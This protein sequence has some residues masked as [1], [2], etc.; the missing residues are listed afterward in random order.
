VQQRLP[1]RLDPPITFAHRGARAHARENTL[2]A[3]ELALKLG[4]SGL[5]SDVWLTADGVAVLDH[6][7]VVK[8]G[9]RRKPISTVLRGD[10]PEHIPT[11]VELLE[12]CGT[13][14]ELSLDVKDPEAAA[15]IVDDV[16]S[17]DPAMLPRTWLCDPDFERCVAN[18]SELPDVKILN[19]TRLGRLKEGPERRAASLAHHGIDGIN[20]HRTDWNGGL[21]ALFH[22]FNLY[23]F[24][25]DL[26]FD[27]Q[28][29]TA[30]RMGLD[31]VFSDNVD[32][33]MDAFNKEIGGPLPQ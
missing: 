7:G 23:A 15:T 20:M 8:R 2:P 14:Y 17:I 19:S 25:W 12:H 27:D 22:R 28:L 24:G 9:I 32:I 26:Q 1:S 31:A 6:D 13:D 10:L 30:F 16:R 4:A 3:F 18:R 21:A 29:E 33:M 11:L 5:E